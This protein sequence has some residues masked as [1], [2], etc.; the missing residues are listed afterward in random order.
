MLTF[1]AM[2]EISKQNGRAVKLNTTET[3]Q[4]TLGESVSGVMELWYL[5]RHVLFPSLS[6]SLPLSL[7]PPP[8][9]IQG[10]SVIPDVES[11]SSSTLPL[12]QRCNYHSNMVLRAIL[13]EYDP[14]APNPVST[15]KIFKYKYY[16]FLY[17]SDRLLL[18]HP[19]FRV[20]LWNWPLHSTPRR[21]GYLELVSAHWHNRWLHGTLNS[22]YVRLNNFHIWEENNV[23]YLNSRDLTLPP[24]P[25][26]FTLFTIVPWYSWTL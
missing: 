8:Y 3:S 21:P 11:S 19:P 9:P 6:L 26:L 24:M 7:L 16:W 18:L 23:V 25:P 13:N 17:F 10:Y 15:K 1:T 5:L 22:W 4:D 2:A 12:L 20:H 14:E